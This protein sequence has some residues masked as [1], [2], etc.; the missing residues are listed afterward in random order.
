MRGVVTAIAAD[1]PGQ[2]GANSVRQLS[3]VDP[4][5]VRISDKACSMVDRD[6]HARDRGSLDEW[7]STFSD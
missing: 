3:E 1:L 4:A 2:L 6:K 5:V 7:L